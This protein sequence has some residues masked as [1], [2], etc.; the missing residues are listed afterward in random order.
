MTLLRSFALLPALFALP[1]LAACGG[2][3]AAGKDSSTPEDT[4]ADTASDTAADSGVDTS[5]G[6][7]PA[8]P[9][10]FTVQLGGARTDNLTFDE[11]TCTANAGSLRVFWRNR[12]RAHVYVLIT[13]I[14]G[15]YTGPGLYD[16]TSGLRL[17]LQ[18]EA[19]G[20]L[21]Y[22]AADAAAGDTLAA[23]VTAG[24]A[25]RASGT[26]TTSGMRGD[27]GQITLSPGSWPI[28]CVT[29]PPS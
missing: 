13:E 11:T 23:E 20:S 10:G 12:A 5:G 28:W 17:K 24:D 22:F 9:T 26:A 14:M 27:E 16:D 15:R 19:G 6:D 2:G 8:A 29:T 25:Y 3:D 18:E 4:S 21:S 7:F 1:L